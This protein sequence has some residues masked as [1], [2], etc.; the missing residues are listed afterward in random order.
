MENKILIINESDEY[1]DR[2]S[3]QLIRAGY[4]V[5]HASNGKAGLDVFRDHRPPVV[6][7][8]ITVSVMNG[9][10]FLRRVEIKPGSS[11][12]VII[13]T[14]FE[15]DENVRFCYNLGARSFLN[16]DHRPEELLTMV[17]FAT[18]MTDY[19]NQVTLAQFEVKKKAEDLQAMKDSYR[20]V[21]MVLEH[22]HFFYEYQ[23]DKVFSNVSSSVKSILGYAP[24]DFILHY[25]EYL[26]QNPLNDHFNSQQKKSLS[27]ISN[28]YE[29]EFLHRSGE[30][31]KL[32]L[33]EIPKKDNNGNVLLV[34]G[35]A[36]D[37]T[38]KEKIQRELLGL[39]KELE[40]IS[41]KHRL[42]EKRLTVRQENIEN[43]VSTWIFEID[44]KSQVT[45][46]NQ[47]VK[48]ILGF[49]GD[50]IIGQDLKKLL[51]SADKKILTAELGMLKDGAGDVDL[52]LAVRGKD[53]EFVNLAVKIMTI[54]EEH[55]SAS[56][57]RFFGSD[58]SSIKKLQNL[59]A[60]NSALLSVTDETIFIINKDGLIKEL[61]TD[62]INILAEKDQSISGKSLFK[63]PVF[64]KF[65][66]VFVET[67]QQVDASSALQTF[68]IEA[69]QN[70]RQMALKV[71]ISGFGD[72][73]Y[74]VAVRDRTNILRARE[75]H[76]ELIRNAQTILDSSIAEQEFLLDGDA[77][78]LLANDFALDL[79]GK[80]A[81]EIQGVPIYE[82]LPKELAS[83]VRKL[84]KSVAVTGK[85]ADLDKSIL[86]T[87]YRV[88]VFPQ[89]EAAGGVK[90]IVLRIK[91]VTETRKLNAQL[92]WECSIR[93]A[94]MDGVADGVFVVDPIGR[95][96]IV[97]RTF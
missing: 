52:E 71:R 50:E 25:R 53:G 20:R 46:S 19:Q 14:D 68:E 44:K 40:E 48:D 17:H 69:A 1:R 94:T 76:T 49:S 13:L 36:T 87:D 63:M 27:G 58:I 86:E 64:K 33:S 10:E 81:Q 23:K 28:E 88:S 22:K 41:D 24:A 6:I 97:S 72:N 62:N 26:S 84:I 77:V 21:D 15:N 47:A 96:R 91:D 3:A 93:S 9:L 38:E 70:S 73:Q 65:Q 67:L 60:Q 89:T 55:E 82:N 18:A 54:P 79:T 29:L 95:I 39:H 30:P 90:S 85:P 11:F 37:I 66:R 57:F 32:L 83:A 43:C 31:R 42:E 16:K 5:L 34:E 78:V 7:L 75:T 56:L 51:L 45:W 80:P 35:I 59:E 4:E 2:V 74:I 8:D 12:S 61:Y 92:D